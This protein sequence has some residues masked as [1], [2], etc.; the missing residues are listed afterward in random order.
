MSSGPISAD[1]LT[2]G[3]TRKPL[4]EKFRRLRDEW[5]TQRGPVSSITKLVLHPAYQKIIGM[6]PDAVPF[7]LQELQRDPDVWFWALRA[8]TEA[9]PVP[10]AIRGNIAAM[11][12]AWLRW[13]REQGYQW[14][15]GG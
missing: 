3:E 4:E 15:N 1:R 12:E 14:S 2:D 6:G 8:I 7:L 10:P 9:D 13:G 11:A 5:K